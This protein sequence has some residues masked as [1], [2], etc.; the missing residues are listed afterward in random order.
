MND[1]RESRQGSVKSALI[2][3]GEALLKAKKILASEP[4]LL[5]QA[6]LSEFDLKDLDL[7]SLDLSSSDLFRGR[8]VVKI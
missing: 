3:G 2:E 7:S 1:T 5:K 6:N 8:F 4:D